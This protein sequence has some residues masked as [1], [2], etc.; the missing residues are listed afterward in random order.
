MELA[1]ART[2]NYHGDDAQNLEGQI[3]KLTESE[4]DQNRGDCWLR[5]TEVAEM[6]VSAFEHA[7]NAEYEMLALA[8]MPNHVHVVF[9]LNSA[10]DHVVQRWKSFTSHRANDILGRRGSFWQADYYDVLIRDSGQLER[11]VKYVIDNPAKGGLTDWPYT[12][13]WSERILE[14]I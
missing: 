10:L 7:D 4:L 3:F 12:R 14:L 6:V 5:N 11:T 13:V 9:Q 2:S 1:L 8:V